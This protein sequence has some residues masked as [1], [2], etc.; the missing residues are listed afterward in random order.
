MAYSTFFALMAEYNTA[1]IELAIISEKYFG[2]TAP[3]AAKRAN[4]NRLPIPAF[5]CG[6]Q[7]SSFM[8]HIADLATH[9]D[10]QREKAQ[11]QW[12]KMNT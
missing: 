1:S 5:R 10:E 12:K 2:L 4:L 3:E 7:K 11:Y 6:T 9:I 8:I